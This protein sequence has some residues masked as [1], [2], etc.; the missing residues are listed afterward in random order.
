MNGNFNFAYVTDTRLSDIGEHTAKEIAEKDKELNF[1][2]VVHGGDALLGNNPEKISIR[3]L[4]MEHERYKNAVKS[5]ILLPVQGEKDGWRNERFKGQLA[6]NIMTDKVW[7]K[8]TSFTDNYKNLLRCGESPYYFMDF[9]EDKVRIIILCSYFYEYDE[10][11][12]LFEKFKGYK[13]NQL[14]WLIKDALNVPA[15]YT[16][17]VFSH[18]VPKSRFE[19]GKDPFIYNSWSTEQNL[20]IFQQ[21]A[22]LKGVNLA[23]W[24]AGGYNNE[25]AV[26]IGGINF[27]TTKSQFNSGIWY[28][29]SID[30]ENR[31]LTLNDITVSY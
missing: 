5:N 3:L 23:G 1:K 31:T 29:I 30:R 13:T 20:I 18:S 2:C 6:M 28:E 21:A 17:V 16:A 11:Y 15:D 22:R 24:I 27:I 9:P 4:N 14:K 10:E 26:E 7:K 19:T 8:A 12:E 25:E